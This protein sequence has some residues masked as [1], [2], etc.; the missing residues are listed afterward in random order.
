MKEFDTIELEEEQDP[1]AFFKA[2]RM[3]KLAQHE[4]S[5]NIEQIEREIIETQKQ[6]DEQ[7]EKLHKPRGQLAK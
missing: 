6:I 1:P 3:T 5:V 4:E 7:L 2:K